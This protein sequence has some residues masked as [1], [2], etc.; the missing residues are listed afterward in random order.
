MAEN[1]VLLDAAKFM[2]SVHATGIRGRSADEQRRI[3]QHF[4]ATCYEDVGKAPRLLDGDD[5]VVALAEHLPRRFGVR[6]PLAAAVPEVLPAFLEHLAEEHVVPAIYELRAGMESAL[7][8]FAHAVSTGAAHR[9]GVV[10]RPG[11]TVV[12]RAEKTGRNDPCPCGSGR[13]FKK[14]CLR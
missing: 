11:K 10:R 1:R 8:A 3:V 14:C 13:K 12:H 4:A 2:D 6:D 9:D 7:A 5:L